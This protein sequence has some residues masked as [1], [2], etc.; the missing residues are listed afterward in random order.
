MTSAPHHTDHTGK[1][2]YLHIADML[3]QAIGAMDLDPSGRLPSER[4]LAQLLG[5]S[6]PSLR[7]ALIVLELR[8]EIEIRMGSGI[9]LTHPT[10]PGDSA[11]APPPQDDALD[12]LLQK[13]GD[14]PRDVNQMR[15]FL[16]SGVAAHAARFI[17]TAQLKQLKKSLTDMRSALA[18]KSRG[19][20]K[21]IADA[22]RLFHTTLAS[23]TDNDLLVQTLEYLFD[24]RYTPVA[25]AMHKHYEDPC[26]WE[27]AVE[28]HQDIYDAIA[29]HDPLQAQAAMQRHLSR[30]HARLMPLIG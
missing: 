5:V 15:F 17:S 13:L 6:R 21:I 7:E 11:G 27:F 20:I 23:C 24:Q 22:D 9:Y 1:R 28:E 30:A 26:S 3:R 25:E 19:S 2:N 29:A 10:E 12:P 4:E 18:K 16:E 14:S 8:Q